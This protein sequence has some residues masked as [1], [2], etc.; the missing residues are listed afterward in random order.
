MTESTNHST[1]PSHGDKSASWH[2][3]CQP[4]CP[5]CLL[6]A[7]KQRDSA[8]GGLANQRRAIATHS[9][10]P[11]P[12]SK[13]ELVPGSACPV[14]PALRAAPGALTHQQ[15]PRD[16]TASHPA[17]GEK[18]PQSCTSGRSGSLPPLAEAAKLKSSKNLFVAI[19]KDPQAQNL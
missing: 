2:S 11:V 1:S 18:P 19:S 14:Q 9:N 16:G 8:R 6:R 17:L 13:Q 12:R 10:I 15:S 3:E 5:G 7:G 4:G